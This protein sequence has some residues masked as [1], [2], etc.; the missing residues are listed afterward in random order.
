MF[1]EVT[2]ASGKGRSVLIN[3]KI[4]KRVNPQNYQTLEGT[5][6]G[7]MLIFQDDQSMTVTNSYEDLTKIVP[8]FRLVVEADTQA[9]KL[10]LS[11]KVK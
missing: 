7:S 9:P 6:E 8:V 3:A 2:E 10:S 1:I 4:I 5:V 11:K